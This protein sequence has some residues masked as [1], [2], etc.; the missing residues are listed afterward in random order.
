LSVGAVVV[1]V[2]LEEGVL[3]HLLGEVVLAVAV[4]HII[5]VYLELLICLLLSQ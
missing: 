2:A 1:A 4:V 5:F 3:L